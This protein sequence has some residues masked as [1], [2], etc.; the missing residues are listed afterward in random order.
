MV[1]DDLKR[2]GYLGGVAAGL[3]GLAGCGSDGEPTDSS[4]PTDT[5]EPTESV[6]PTGTAE[7]TATQALSP[8]D[9]SGPEAGGDDLSPA[10]VTTGRLQNAVGEQPIQTAFD[11]LVVPVGEGLGMDAAV[12]PAESETPVQDAIDAI[13]AARG[14]GNR[15]AVLLPPGVVEE[16][17]SLTGTR[18]KS[19][20]G[21]G[22]QASRL[23]F[24]ALDEPGIT[25]DP[26]IARDAGYTYWDGIRFEGAAG[27]KSD[28]TRTAPAVHIR[29]SPETEPPDAIRG[30]NLGHVRFQDWDDP[31][32]HL[33]G[34][35]I[36]ESHWTWVDMNSFNTGRNVLV[37]DTSLGG[38]SWTV[39]KLNLGRERPGRLFDARTARGGR[40]HVQNLH[41]R[42]NAAGESD[43][44]VID[45]AG[46]TNL[47]V[48]VAQAEY[49][50]PDADLPC[51]FRF[52][53][54]G[55]YHLG[56]AQYQVDRLAV[57]H[58]V[59]LRRANDATIGQW[60]RGGE[61]EVR[62]APLGLVG[63]QP[64]GTVLFHGRSDE[65]HNAVGSRRG[66][67]FALEDRRVADPLYAGTVTHSGDRTRIRG[68]NR[69]Q[70]GSV[71]GSERRRFTPRLQRLRPTAMPDESYAV[72]HRFEWR[73]DDGFERWDLVLEWDL[74]PGREVEFEVEVTRRG[75]GH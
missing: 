11:G 63:D 16:A 31:V 4:E 10:Q 39:D 55:R 75:T 68:V 37:E 26:S 3:V 53:G 45:I 20:V 27:A 23:R 1:L 69:A 7:T 66:R 74:D 49:E 50:T 29:Q 44:P 28:A 54:G 24:T 2:R 9:H 19:F 71:I 65:V 36:F 40:F 13:G 51:V 46:P 18:G 41:F 22:V 34:A 70:D 32:I 67:V 12:D 48:T 52:E 64:F 8:H 61:I 47:Q 58:L 56:Q 38:S 17:G 33:D 57:D 14:Q 59:E 25:Q 73:T 6:E 5:G 21:W 72:D 62:E 60:D 30:F 42:D 35:T 43:A 15:G